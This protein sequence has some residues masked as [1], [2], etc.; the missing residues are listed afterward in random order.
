[1]P[2][3]SLSKTSIFHP[4]LTKLTVERD[5]TLKTDVKTKESY[6]ILEENTHQVNKLLLHG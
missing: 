3:C 1:M 4:S 5:V 2:Y 6:K